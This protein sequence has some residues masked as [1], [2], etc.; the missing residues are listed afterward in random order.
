MSVDKFDNPVVALAGRKVVVGYH[1]WLWTYGLSYNQ[2]D[3]DIRRMLTGNASKEIFQKYG[4]T[5]AIFFNESTDYLINRD[6]FKAN[7]KLIYNQDG[8]EL[9]QI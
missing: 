6:Y 7:Y 1:A 9:Y 8:Y 2:R 3:T 4:I 5:D